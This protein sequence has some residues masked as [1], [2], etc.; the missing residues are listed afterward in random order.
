MSA[1]EYSFVRRLRRETEPEPTP[2]AG[3]TTQD[4]LSAAAAAAKLEIALRRRGL[5]AA[6]DATDDRPRVSV[7]LSIESATQLADWLVVARRRR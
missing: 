6:N 3:R 1:S 4:D 2:S 5:C 7:E